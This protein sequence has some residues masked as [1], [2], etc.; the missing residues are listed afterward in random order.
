MWRAVLTTRWNHAVGTAQIHAAYSTRGRP[1]RHLSP[2]GCYHLCAG[3]YG[4]V[5]SGHH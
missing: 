2:N 1:A 5:G 4:L 3:R